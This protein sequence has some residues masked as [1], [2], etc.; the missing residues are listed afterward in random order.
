MNSE[1]S[2]IKIEISKYLKIFFPIIFY[3]KTLPDTSNKFFK[4]SLDVQSQA[5]VV[6]K[7]L[8]HK[9]HEQE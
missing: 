3:L 6:T 4:I 7:A 1:I 8:L 5:I 2:N 9:A